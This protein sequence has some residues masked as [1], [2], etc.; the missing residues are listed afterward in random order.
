MIKGKKH[1]KLLLGFSFE[2]ARRIADTKENYYRYE[3]EVELRE[4]GTKKT[5][6]R[7][8]LKRDSPL[9]HLQKKINKHIFRELEYPLYL[10]G[11]IPK[12]SNI[13][14]AK[15]HQGRKYKF[16]TDISRFFPH[17][18]PQ[19]VTYGLR[20]VGFDSKTARLI[21]DLTTITGRVPQSDDLV[22]HVPEGANC[23]PFVA[24]IAFMPIDQQI[25]DLCQSKSIK[26]TRYVDDLCFSAQYDFSNI[27]QSIIGIVSRNGFHI[28][29]KKTSASRG[30]MII[31]G[32]IPL[33]NRL[34]LPDH[35]FDRVESYPRE[36]ENYEL[37]REG[38][39]RY[40]Y[41]VTDRPLML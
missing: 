18:S 27:H 12:R 15:A 26:Y 40:C 17:I 11:S 19:M 31:T 10:F 20:F 6:H 3:S 32:I 13:A 29:R 8:I 4:D 24:N 9:W 30:K 37:R 16:K 21:S 35:F 25:F 28:N 5:R 33:N 14:N 22:P 38:A 1:F 41:T 34:T 39:D 2:D 23:S 36:D 7:Y